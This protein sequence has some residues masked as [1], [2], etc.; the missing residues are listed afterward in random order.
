MDQKRRRIVVGVDGSA[1]SK[2]ALRW[3][4][5]QAKLSGATLDAVAAWNYP[6]SYGWAPVYPDSDSL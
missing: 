1:G 3:A 4:A 2:A 5:A 6:A